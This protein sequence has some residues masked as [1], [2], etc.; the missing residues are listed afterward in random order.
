[1]SLNITRS[2]NASK[3]FW[4]NGSIL[5]AP[6]LRKALE[7]VAHQLLTVFVLSVHFWLLQWQPFYLG[8]ICNDLN[9]CITTLSPIFEGSYFS[10]SKYTLVSSLRLLYPGFFFSFSMPH[11]PVASIELFNFKT[12]SNISLLGLPWLLQP[13]LVYFLT[14]LLQ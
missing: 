3:I 12:I 10:F 5:W 2:V 14:L 11:P 6:L 1:M 13:Q 9:H 4:F 7:A 8:H